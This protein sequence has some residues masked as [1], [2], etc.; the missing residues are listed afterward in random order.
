[1]F[2]LTRSRYHAILKCLSCYWDS[3]AWLIRDGWSSCSEPPTTAAC[4]ETV[5]EY[6]GKSGDCPR[7]F[8][9]NKPTRTEWWC[10]ILLRTRSMVLTYS[11]WKST[12]KIPGSIPGQHCFAFLSVGNGPPYHF[13]LSMMPVLQGMARCRWHVI[14]G[15]KFHRQ[16]NPTR[17]GYSNYW[18]IAAK[19]GN[20]TQSLTKRHHLGHDKKIKRSQTISHKL[21]WN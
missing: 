10:S 16:S 4:D 17:I 6:F 3:F 9:L 12:T 5:Y 8:Y 7:R 1:M 14:W 15:L 18:I 13:V 19:K 2:P 11:T 21:F 20:D